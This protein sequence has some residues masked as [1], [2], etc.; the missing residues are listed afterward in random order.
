MRIINTQKKLCNRVFANQADF[1]LFYDAF[2]NNFR[3]LNK[4]LKIKTHFLAKDGA[5]PTP[6]KSIFGAF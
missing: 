3:Q 6:G 2:K 5:C 4:L 1:P